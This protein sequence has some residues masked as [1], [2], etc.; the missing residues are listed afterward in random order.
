MSL[1]RNHSY[2]DSTLSRWSAAGDDSSKDS[3]FYR[4]L[5]KAVYSRLSSRLNTY[6]GCE[7][8]WLVVMSSSLVQ[9]D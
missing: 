3:S 5:F 4:N 8:V 7:L 9:I 2:T 1:S 6:S